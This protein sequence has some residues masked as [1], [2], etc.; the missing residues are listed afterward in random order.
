MK[1]LTI[2]TERFC[3]EY[4]N[5]GGNA[6]EAHEAAYGYSH[7]T[8]GFN[9]VS[10]LLDDPRVFLK[11]QEFRAQISS[12]Y[13][14]TRERIVEE[15]ASVAFSDLADYMDHDGKTLIVKSLSDLPRRLTRAVSQIE[16][17]DTASGP[18]IR[19]K[20]HDK[21]VA[22]DKLN[23]MAG[24]YANDHIDVKVNFVL[25]APTVEASTQAW[26]EKNPALPDRKF[27]DLEGKDIT[28]KTDPLHYQPLEHEVAAQASR[29]N[30]SALPEITREQRLRLD[31]NNSGPRPGSPKRIP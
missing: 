23:K 30:P 13:K 24:N 17:I 9:N 16:Q 27:L 5:N 25:R 26:V 31:S 14:V 4:V 11:I 29:E 1:E 18:V 22:L 15:L 12:E 21:L 3:Q 2:K 19:L 7:K 6:D 10:R 28:P 20:F 8:S